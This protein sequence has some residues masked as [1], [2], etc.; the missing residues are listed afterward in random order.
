MRWASIQYA[1]KAGQLSKVTHADMTEE[2]FERD[3][4]GRLL[5]HVDALDRCTTWSY[6]APGF[7]ERVDALE[8][9]LRYRWDKL[10]RLIGL[11]NQNASKR[12]FPLRPGRPPAAGDRLRW[13]DHATS[14]TRAA[15]GW[16][17]PR[18]A[19]AASTCASTPWGAWSS[20]RRLGDQQQR[21][22]FAYDGN[23]KLIQALNAV[24]KLQWFLMKPAT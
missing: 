20:V 19:S 18:L 23:G 17:A 5:A 1:Y 14:T 10:G 13:P 9:T 3:A 24:S 21:E 7:A 4:E 22:T 6:T 11:E 12:H 16:R 8:H 15:V 2:R